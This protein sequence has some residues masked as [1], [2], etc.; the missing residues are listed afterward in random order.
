MFFNAVFELLKNRNVSIMFQVGSRHA[1]IQLSDFERFRGKGE[2][3]SSIR[4]LEK[5][6]LGLQVKLLLMIS[7]IKKYYYACKQKCFVFTVKV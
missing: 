5:Q 3:V 7:Q 1:P 4:C 2:I 6:V